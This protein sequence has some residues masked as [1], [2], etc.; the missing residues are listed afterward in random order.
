MS[1]RHEKTFFLWGVVWLGP[2]KT[3]R[4]HFGNCIRYS[5]RRTVVLFDATLT[6]TREKQP[7][8]VAVLW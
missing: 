3:T 2:L 5:F 1:L 6:P 7:I 8:T 4:N